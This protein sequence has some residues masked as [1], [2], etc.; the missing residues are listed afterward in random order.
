MAFITLLGT[1]VGPGSITRYSMS[2]W[3]GA[4]ADI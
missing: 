3:N 2:G 4:L 1:F